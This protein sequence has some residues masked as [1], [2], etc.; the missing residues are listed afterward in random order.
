MQNI[1]DFFAKFHNFKHE[2]GAA[3]FGT[4]VDTMY[5]QSPIPAGGLEV[6]IFMTFTHTK[7]WVIDKLKQFVHFQTKRMEDTFCLDEDDED[8][9]DQV[10]DI[11]V[12]EDDVPVQD[13]NVAP[14]DDNFDQ[15]IA[16]LSDV[17]EE[18]IDLEI[19]DLTDVDEDDDANNSVIIIDRLL[20]G[21]IFLSIL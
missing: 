15:E 13:E 10:A 12:D 2:G 1:N 9:D 3:V 17:D 5:R 11:V 16:D 18:N 7:K 20:L 8:N 19:A 4:V 14:D 21:F 6:P